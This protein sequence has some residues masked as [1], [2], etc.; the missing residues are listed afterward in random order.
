MKKKVRRS[1][2]GNSIQRSRET[3]W[4]SRTILFS[5]NSVEMRHLADDIVDLAHDEIRKQLTNNPPF[6]MKVYG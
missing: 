4:R 1:K 5:A 6:S 2:N 3:G